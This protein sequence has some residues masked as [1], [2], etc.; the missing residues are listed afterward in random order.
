MLLFT[1]W[2]TGEPNDAN[3]NEDCAVMNDPGNGNWN[4]ISTL[5]TREEV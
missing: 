3:K 4:D 5:R 1:N 2:F